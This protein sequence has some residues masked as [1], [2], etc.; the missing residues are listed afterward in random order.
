M[1]SDSEAQQRAIPE[2]RRRRL[3]PKRLLTLVL[4]IL[5]IIS[6]RRP[7]KNS[8]QPRLQ[9]DCLGIDAIRL[10]PLRP[11]TFLDLAFGRIRLLCFFHPPAFIELLQNAGVRAELFSRKHT[12]RLRSVQGWRAND[13]P[14]LH[15]G[16]AIAYF[17]REVPFVVDSMRLHEM[18][19]NWA[20]PSSLA[21]HMADGISL[22]PEVIIPA[23]PVSPESKPETDSDHGLRRE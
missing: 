6:E 12:N 10:R 2:S 13:L 16:R 4:F 23:K 3:F 14:P 18:V 21:V 9:A 17:V 20:C 19:F 1:G 11:R 15:D 5:S 22:A 7:T 8:G